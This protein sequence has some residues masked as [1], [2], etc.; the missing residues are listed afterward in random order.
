MENLEKMKESNCRLCNRVKYESIHHL[1]PVSMHRKKMFIRKFGKKEMRER[2]AVLCRDCHQHIHKT[3][4]EKYLA[5][6]L[7]TVESLL[8]DEKIKKFLGFI[9]KQS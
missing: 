8:Q 3:Y 6:N 1:I 9:R 7:N 5:L 2:K 4:D